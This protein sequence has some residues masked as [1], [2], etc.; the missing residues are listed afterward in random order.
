MRTLA[1]GDIH[2]C[3]RAFE[4]LLGI[5]KPV[6][7]DH[8]VTLGDYV[9]RGPNS[10]GV[11]DRLVEMYRGGNL[12][13]LRG[14]HDQMMLDAR[15]DY[16]TY[17]A[18]LGYGGDATLASYASGGRRGSLDDVPDAHW[19]F[20]ESDCVNYY[21][22]AT[23]IFVHANLY[24][25]LPLAEQPLYA[26]HYEKFGRPSPHVSG[27]VMVCGHTAQKSGAPID[28]GHAICLDTWVY[29]QG[30]LSGL[31]LASGELWQANQYGDTRVGSIADF[32]IDSED[33]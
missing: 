21:E 23:H 33:L 10:A 25:D 16:R 30:W 8:I 31:D 27:K 28:I 20:L 19:H 29:G 7:A 11:L 24:P 32:R 3:L 13:A 18:W 4:A 14:N 12:V 5:M 15:H 22:T 9:D 17:E 6:A 26:L 2:G 1:I